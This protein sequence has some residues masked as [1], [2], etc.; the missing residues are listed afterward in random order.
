MN[1]AQATGTTLSL[2]PRLP[3]THQHLTMYTPIPWRHQISPGAPDSLTLLHD[4]QKLNQFACKHSW[5]LKV[6]SQKCC[7]GELEESGGKKAKT[8][9]KESKQTLSTNSSTCLERF[10]GR[11]KQW[12]RER[13]ALENSRKTYRPD[14][15]CLPCHK[16]REKLQRRRRRK[17][18]CCLRASCWRRGC[19]RAESINLQ[20]SL[21]LCKNIHMPDRSKVKFS[22]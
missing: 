5:K 13:T 10:C 3:S 20:V 11:I 21:G 15:Q 7:N 6:C 14:Q 9:E 2:S 4:V 17:K 1:C 12:H 18:M 8:R 19:L 22:I 16:A